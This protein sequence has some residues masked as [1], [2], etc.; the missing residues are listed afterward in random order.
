MLANQTSCSPSPTPAA[1][2]PTPAP[3]PSTSYFYYSGEYCNSA[4]PV[5]MRFTVDQSLNSVFETA[6]A[7]VCVRITGATFGPAF[8][9]DL[10]DG[11]SYVGTNCSACPSPPPTAPPP[12][13]TVYEYYDYEPCTGGSA[14]SGAVYSVEVVAGSGSPG[15]L[16]YDG[17]IYSVTGLGGYSAPANYTLLTGY[18]SANCGAC[19]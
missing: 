8:D 12:T 9:I 2:S 19:L 16:S 7:Y 14:Y 18:S 15:C 1:P 11:S 5:V 10:G 17:T 4:T 6:T 3:P 13:P